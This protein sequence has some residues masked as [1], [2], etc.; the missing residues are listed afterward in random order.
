MA[1][2]SHVT[3]SSLI[4]RWGRTHMPSKDPQIADITSRL[5]K[6]DA[7]CEGTDKKIAKLKLDPAYQERTLV[8]AELAKRR[9]SL[10]A[11]KRAAWYKRSRLNRTKTWFSFGP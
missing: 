3:L 8:R 7:K 9:S 1:H 2:N 6:L 11:K 4:H 10:N 5:A